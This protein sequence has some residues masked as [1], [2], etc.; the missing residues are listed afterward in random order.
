MTPRWRTRPPSLER[1][2]R[3]VD[4]QVQAAMAEDTV[5]QL[6][7]FFELKDPA[8]F[9]KIWQEAYG[10]T[11]AATEEEKSHQYSFSFTEENNSLKQ[12]W[13]PQNNLP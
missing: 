8:A 9:R 1:R 7:P 10:A 4:G 12:C 2:R 11:K 13:N 5:L 3:V 6:Y